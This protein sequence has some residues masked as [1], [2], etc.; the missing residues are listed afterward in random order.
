[1]TTEQALAMFWER[2]D[3]RF[4]GV[5]RKKLLSDKGK[6]YVIPHAARNVRL[7]NS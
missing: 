2:Y 6:E 1:M 7:S 4:S 5:A 3:T